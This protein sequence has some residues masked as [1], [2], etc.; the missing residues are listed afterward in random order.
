MG[1]FLSNTPE[2]DALDKAHANRTSVQKKADEEKRKTMFT[3]G[4][5]LAIIGIIILIVYYLVPA[6][7]NDGYLT[8]GSVICAI[9]IILFITSIEF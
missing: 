2:D 9:G 7:H 5:V 6:A 4:I 1:G 8:A 3:I